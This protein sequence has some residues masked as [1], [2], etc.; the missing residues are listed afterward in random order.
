M[1]MKIWCA[2]ITLAA[3]VTGFSTVEA[4]AP[5]SAADRDARIADLE[6]MVKELAEQ[7][8]TLRTEQEADE[9]ARKRGVDAQ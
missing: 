3:L 6:R 9:E 7:V 4:Q 5:Q 8:Q 1:R 2:G